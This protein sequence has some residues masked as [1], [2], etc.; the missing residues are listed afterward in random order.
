MSTRQPADSPT[1]GPWPL[2]ADLAAHTLVRLSSGTLVA[3][4]AANADAIGF[5][6]RDGVTGDKRHVY[7]VADGLPKRA[8]ATAS[9]SAGAVLY[10]GA[11]G[12]VDDSGTIRRGIALDAAGA[13]NDF[14]DLLPTPA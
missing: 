9:F 13:A 1:V 5:L 10:Q 14:I 2:G 4:G 12:T 3:A 6:T 8:I 7:P 11:A